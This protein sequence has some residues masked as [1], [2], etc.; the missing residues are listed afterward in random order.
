R[1]CVTVSSW[2][3]STASTD[4]STLALHDALPICHVER[5]GTAVRRPLVGD[6]QQQRR[7]AD[8]GFSREQ[9]DDT[10]NEPATEHSVELRDTGGAGSG[11]LEV[12]LGD[13][14]GR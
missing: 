10:R 6:L 2:S 12:D 4:S 13:G 1:L 8:P 5:T 7:L 14:P 9:D 11:G 3:I